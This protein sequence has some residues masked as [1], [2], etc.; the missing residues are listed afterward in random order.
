MRRAPLTRSSNFS[1]SGQAKIARISLE[2]HPFLR[3]GRQ[4]VMAMAIGALEEI[5]S[6]FYGASSRSAFMDGASLRGGFAGG[7]IP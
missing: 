4:L 6:D 5:L 7:P 1:Y 3:A 2:M